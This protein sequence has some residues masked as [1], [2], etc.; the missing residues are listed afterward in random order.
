ME[1]ETDQQRR[2]H[3]PRRF[4]VF[5][6]GEFSPRRRRSVSVFCRPPLFSVFFLPQNT[7]LWGLLFLLAVSSVSANTS[8]WWMRRFGKL[9]QQRMRADGRTSS[10]YPSGFV[11]SLPFRYRFSCSSL[12]PGS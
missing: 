9:R 5:R 12:L 3:A 4:G 6:Y 2:E 7:E 8:V 10:G 1:K 11:W